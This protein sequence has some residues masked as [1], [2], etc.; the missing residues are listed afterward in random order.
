MSKRFGLL[1]VFILLTVFMPP[2]KAAMPP[3]APSEVFPCFDDG[4]PI[5]KGRAK[6]WVLPDRLAAK[7]PCTYWIKIGWGYPRTDPDNQYVLFLAPG[8]KFNWDAAHAPGGFSFPR[9]NDWGAQ[10]L[11]GKYVCRYPFYRYGF[12]KR[13]YAHNDVRSVP[14]CVNK[15]GAWVKP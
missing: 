15:N 14:K 4:K 11:K 6:V 10:L 1:S 13:V 9:V 8:K 7:N 12:A 3:I 5:G 2:A